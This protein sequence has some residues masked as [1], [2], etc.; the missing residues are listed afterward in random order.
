VLL[1]S[2]GRRFLSFSFGQAGMGCCASQ[3]MADGRQGRLC[4]GSSS[5]RLA[6]AV[7]A[8]CRQQLQAGRLVLMEQLCS[9]INSHHANG[10]GCCWQAVGGCKRFCV[11]RPAVTT[12][13]VEGLFVQSVSKGR[14]GPKGQQPACRE[15]TGARL[16]C[17][18]S[19][20]LLGLSGPVV[21]SL[22]GARRF[23][24]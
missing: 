21:P 22:G 19:R 23:R 2:S 10:R 4:A 18:R 7:S 17:Q 24:R 6:A 15:G 13:G 9:Q 20:R 11:L 16:G 5:S 14:Q 8:G 3:L 1:G 12:R